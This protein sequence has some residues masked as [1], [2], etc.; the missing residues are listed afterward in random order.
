MAEHIGGLLAKEK[1][2]LKP[3]RKIQMYRKSGFI[4]A[5]SYSYSQKKKT[6]AKFRV[7]KDYTKKSWVIQGHLDFA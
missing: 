5:I 3:K 2:N 6:S 4:T 1:F 7:P